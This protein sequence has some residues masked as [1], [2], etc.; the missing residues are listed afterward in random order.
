[1]QNPKL[2]E[3]IYSIRKNIAKILKID[4]EG[5]SVK[6]TT[7][8]KLGFVCEGQGIVAFANTLLVK[9]GN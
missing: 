1:M 3:Y 8:D 6:A 2:K 4:V 5:V 7:T 9:N